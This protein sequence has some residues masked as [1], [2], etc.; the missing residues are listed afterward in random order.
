MSTFHA[1]FI[2]NILFLRTVQP[3]VNM[4]NFELNLHELFHNE[5]RVAQIEFVRHFSELFLKQSRFSFI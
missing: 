1:T 3:A 4:D 2:D 5:L